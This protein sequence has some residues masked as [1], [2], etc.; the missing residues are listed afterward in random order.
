MGEIKNT[1]GKEIKE[2]EVLEAKEV[3]KEEYIPKIV[4]GS[5][6]REE[7]VNIKPVESGG[8]WS[9]LLVAGQDN[10]KDP[11]L[12]NKA[13]RSY[14]VPLKTYEQG[15]GVTHILDDIKRVHILKYHTVFPE[16]MTQ[17]EF[18]EKELGTNLN[19]SLKVDENF[20][21]TDKRSRVTLTRKGLTLNLSE[22]IDM[23]KYLI[24]NHEYD[25]INI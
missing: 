11:F 24:S 19:P 23:L 3:K 4:Y 9:N 5:F 2:V 25:D 13:K 14:Q 22:P 20:W 21:R 15:G 10:K 7:R 1:M 12:Y 18:F 17:K 6:L 8:K 16:G